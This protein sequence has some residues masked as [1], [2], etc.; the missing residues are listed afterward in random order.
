[1]KNTDEFLN[2]S[3]KIVVHYSFQL[4]IIYNNKTIQMFRGEQE[5]RL[6]FSI[7]ALCLKNKDKVKE[8]LKNQK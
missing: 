8:Q 5:Q 7:S 6:L 4:D 2:N 3:N 1:M